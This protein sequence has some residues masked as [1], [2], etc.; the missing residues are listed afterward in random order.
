[1]QHGIATIEVTYQVLSPIDPPIEAQIVSRLASGT[2]RFDVDRG[3]IVSQQ[4][5]VDRRI[6]AFAGPRSSMHYVSRFTERLLP[7]KKNVAGDN[8]PQDGSLE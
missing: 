3:R 4:L 7:D 8:R 2:V 5:D 1:V 6:V